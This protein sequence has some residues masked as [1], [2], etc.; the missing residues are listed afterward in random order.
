MKPIKFIHLSDLHIG[1]ETHGKINPRTGRNTRLE[2]VLGSL[3]FIVDAAVRE[4]VDLVLIAGDVF[5]RGN[6]H[7]TEETEFARRIA[8]LA[9]EASCR[10]VIVLGN[11][12]YAGGFGR[13][14]AVE[15]FPALGLRGVHVAKKPDLLRIET[16]SGWV[17]AA[18]L[19]WAG[20][21]ALLTK[22]A[23][24]SLSPQELQSAMERM[25]IGIIRDF[26][27]RIDKSIPALFLGHLATRE[28]ERSGTEA[29]TLLISDPAVPASE[30]RN[31]AFA[32]V[33]LG[34]IHRFQNLNKLS[35]PPVIYSGSVERIDFSEEKEKK[36]FVLGTISEEAVGG[37]T[38]DFEFIETPARRFVTI[39]VEGDDREV[40]RAILA[41]IGA[42]SV[43]EAVVRVRRR[44]LSRESEAADEKRIR[45]LLG[46]AHSIKIESIFESQQRAGRQ[47]EISKAS[48]IIEALET[49]IALK[50]ELK[51]VSEEMKTLAQELLREIEG[52]SS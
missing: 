19:P 43:S 45:E 30:L 35:S 34:H 39:D 36:G 41:R 50:P 7:P 15:I 27:E 22:E 26:T 13:A 18:C 46:D 29:S 9:D 5:H 17:Q 44:G 11:H 1:F 23:Y 32:Y 20:R 38:C 33:A 10:V 21:S 24:K 3:D 25:L 6:P 4:C 12:D 42:D 47:T 52:A 28:A 37:W 8:R 48:G 51:E 31:S 16:K 2:D 49:Y 40:E 14:A